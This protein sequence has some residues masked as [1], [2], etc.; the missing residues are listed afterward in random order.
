MHLEWPVYSMELRPLI[1]R[2]PTC[3]VW[4]S[5]S[6]IRFIC[7]LHY[8]AENTFV[9]LFWINM[10]RQVLW[11]SAS[12]IGSPRE[13]FAQPSPFI[14]STGCRWLCGLFDWVLYGMSSGSGKV[15]VITTA[16][17]RLSTAAFSFDSSHAYWIYEQT[18]KALNVAW[19]LAGGF[20]SQCDHKSAGKYS[21]YLISETLIT[22]LWK[23]TAAS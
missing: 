19:R 11:R 21:F 5:T 2:D 18:T 14:N 8:P 20:D 1:S 6:K 16:Q 13:L 17:N 22:F 9:A 12:G 23:L 15:V 3:Y 7:A 4:L 10:N